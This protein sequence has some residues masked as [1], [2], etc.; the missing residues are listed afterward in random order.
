VTR[1]RGLV[2]AGIVVV[3]LAAFVVYSITLKEWCEAQQQ[4]WNGGAWGTTGLGGEIGQCIRDKS[5][6]SF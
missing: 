2:V 1:A 6:F 4:G 3:A 5:I